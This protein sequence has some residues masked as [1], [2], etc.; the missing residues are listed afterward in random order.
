MATAIDQ[1][2]PLAGR[3]RRRAGLL[4]RIYKH[5]ADYLYILPALIVMFVVIGYPVYYVVELSFFNTPPSLAMSE[6]VFVGFDNYSRILQARSFHEVTTNTVVWTVFS[7]FFAFVL[8][9][10]AAL[11]LDKAFFLRGPLRG[12]LLIPFVISAVAASF[13]W[14]W[15]YNSDIGV[16]GAFLVEI[17]LTDRP[18]N[19]LDNTQTVLASLIV[20]NVWREFPFAMIMMLAGLQTVPDELHRAAKMDGAS[21]I[22]R[23]TH[24]TLPHLKSVTLITVLLL[25]VNNLNSFII[26]WIMTGGGPAGASDIWITAIYQLAFG[27]VRFGIASAYS[28]ILFMVMMVLG[29]FYV[30]AMTRGD[31]RRAE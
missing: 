29:Y 16:I 20:V 27:R 30:R 3:G 19:F 18:L 9:F 15:M 24:V 6:K 2:R 13:V 14:R 1:S 26:P 8:G 17:G 23:F 31:E 10:G 22:Q 5:R 4:A 25:T 21:V 11:A 12:A 28:V 7:T